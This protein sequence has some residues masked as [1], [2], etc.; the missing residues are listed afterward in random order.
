MPSLVFLVGLHTIEAVERFDRH[1]S[2]FRSAMMIL[3]LLCP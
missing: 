2:D 1:L 3:A